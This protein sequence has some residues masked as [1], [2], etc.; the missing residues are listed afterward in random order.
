MKGHHFNFKNMLIEVKDLRVGDEIIIPCHSDLR[1]L[2]ILREPKLKRKSQS[3]YKAVYCSTN[4]TE[5]PH[6]HTWTGGTTQTYITK[7]YKCSA[8]GH[9]KE[10]YQNL[11]YK[12]IW[13]IKRERE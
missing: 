10:M 9:N 12:T 4:V 8:E 3:Q 13:L 1:Y 6:T 11:N 7:A 5:T 2:R